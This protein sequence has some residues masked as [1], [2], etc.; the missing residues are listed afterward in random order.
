[1]YGQRGGMLVHDLL[2]LRV[3]RA[4]GCGRPQVRRLVL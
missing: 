2:H 4:Q 3:I 1:M